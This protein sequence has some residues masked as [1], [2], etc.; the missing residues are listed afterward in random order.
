[1]I[2]THLSPLL[3]GI[4]LRSPT[5][6]TPYSRPPAS[7]ARPQPPWKLEWVPYPLDHAPVPRSA[8]ANKPSAALRSP[9]AAKRV[10]PPSTHF[11]RPGRLP[12]SGDLRIASSQ[13]RLPLSPRHLPSGDQNAQFPCPFLPG[14]PQAAPWARYDPSTLATLEE[15]PCDRYCG[16]VWPYQEDLSRSDRGGVNH[17]N[18]CGGRSVNRAY[19][20]RREEPSCGRGNSKRTTLRTIFDRNSSFFPEAYSTPS[21]TQVRSPLYISCLRA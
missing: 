10:N 8:P 3:R 6:V 16:I 21:W 19:P 12:R 9:R 11:S 20:W 18:T 1:M 13:S 2:S 7:A 15:Q 5:R 17:R 14:S 4:R